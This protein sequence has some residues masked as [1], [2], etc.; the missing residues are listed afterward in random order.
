MIKN[1][2]IIGWRN[3][4]RTKGYSVI[5][6]GG[7]AIGMAIAIL[8]GLW[9][10]D[11]VSYNKSFKNHDRLGQLYHHITFGEEILSIPDVPAP[12]GEVLRNSYAEFEEVAIA[13]DHGDHIIA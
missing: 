1:Y 5:N 12:I 4:I 6:I 8:I 13:S 3:I 7:L 9:V 2:L 10:F 11:E